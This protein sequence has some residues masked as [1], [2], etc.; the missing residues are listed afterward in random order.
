MIRSFKRFILIFVVLTLALPSF[1]QVPPQLV[2]ALKRTGL[3]DE[4]INGLVQALPSVQGDP[5]KIT[6]LLG[7]AGLM[8]HRVQGFLNDPQIGA[9]A[10]GL[11]G[12][13]PDDVSGIVEGLEKAKAEELASRGITPEAI[14]AVL[15]GGS[16]AEMEEIAKGLGVCVCDVL[17]AVEVASKA[18]NREGIGEL[19][20]YGRGDFYAAMVT[21]YDAEGLMKFYGLNEESIKVGLAAF[22][23]GDETAFAAVLGSVGMNSG[24]WA[25]LLNMFA[26]ADPELLES[27]LEE[28]G[29]DIDAFLSAFEALDMEAYPDDYADEDGMDEDGMDEDG[30]DEDADGDGEDADGDG[31]DADDD[32]EGEGD[33]SDG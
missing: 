8:P 21:A 9:V 32:G 4:Q 22:A 12:I 6:G 23:A 17:A 10:L 15:A 11:L 3:S 2:E 13:K 27:Y 20:A 33:K 14:D 5:A 29:V 19:A 24:E 28:A 7:Q 30:M 16:L 26:M 31:E 1:A 18:T 25:D